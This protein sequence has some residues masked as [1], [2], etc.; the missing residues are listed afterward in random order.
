MKIKK[1]FTYLLLLGLSHAFAQDNQEV[2]D[3][4]TN[5]LNQNYAIE[6]SKV[7]SNVDDFGVFVKDTV[8]YFSS[9][10]EKRRAV[11]VINYQEKTH[12]F[13]IYSA[14]L[15][16]E[17]IKNK[18]DNLPGNVNTKLNESISFIT[19]DG[20]TMYFT[21]NKKG[22]DNN[23]RIFRAT[24]RDGV[25][26]DI[27]DLPINNSTF[28][29][30]QAVLN[31]EENTMYFVSDRGSADGNTNIYYVPLHKDGS[32][33]IVKAM[34]YQINTSKKEVTPFITVNNE[35]Y[36][37][38]NGH[39]G[40]GGLD[41]FYVDLKANNPKV[42]S[43]G[44][45]VNSNRD[46]FSFSID[47][48]TQKGFVSSNK[49]GVFNIYRV[50]EKIA[51]QE[52]IREETS[53]WNIAQ[54]RKKLN[55]NVIVSG[56]H[57]QTFSALKLNFHRKTATL[58]KED[59]LALDELIAYVQQK[60]PKKGIDLNTL[61]KEENEATI[62]YNKRLKNIANYINGRVDTKLTYRVKK[63]KIAFYFKYNSSQLTTDDKSTLDQLIPQLKAN[64]SLR[65]IIEVH[66]DSRGS[67][68]Y[69]LKL[70]ALRLKRIKQ[71]LHSKGVWLH[72]MLGIAFGETK[73][74]NDCVDGKNCSEK[75]HKE[76]RRV[77]YKV[78]SIKELTFNRL[79][80]NTEN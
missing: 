42:I 21:G 60:Y 11:K 62:T 2:Y 29:N 79:K 54:K 35:L 77:M 76:N 57:I 4:V 48:Q 58:T 80:N 51:I 6:K 71:Y 49:A 65:I 73:L 14:P 43:L 34:P 17:G 9:N 52:L 75:K 23:L 72:Q 7:N 50:Q 47:P 41:V 53:K 68:N 1:Q 24:L 59:Q 32:F 66:A 12:L 20:S 13:D 37:S 31:A 26:T 67:S 22:K 38:S 61:I 3:K 16:S 70:T 63:K 15:T 33:G 10:R 36:F 18:A 45:G 19:K 69:N 55:Q 27:E 64:R 8:V 46:D 44:R 56:N 74:L 78:L 30:G 39:G 40:V 5:I 25:W 28:S